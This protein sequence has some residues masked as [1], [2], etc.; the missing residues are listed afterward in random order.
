MDEETYKLL[1]NKGLM[2]I[3][4]FSNSFGICYYEHMIFFLCQKS[5]GIVSLTKWEDLLHNMMEQAEWKL[6]MHFLIQIYRGKNK[7]V[8]IL[9]FLKE[10]RRE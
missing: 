6:A 4:N 8:N 3:D 7:Y 1:I 10:E 2:N 9:G 5:L